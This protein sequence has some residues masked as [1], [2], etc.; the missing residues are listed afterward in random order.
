MF[1]SNCL[2]GGFRVTSSK[3][4]GPRIELNKSTWQENV[5]EID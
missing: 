2:S 5:F 3:S 4:H 1:V